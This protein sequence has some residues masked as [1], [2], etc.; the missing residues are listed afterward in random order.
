[1]RLLDYIAAISAYSPDEPRDEKGEWTSEGGMTKLSEVAALPKHLKG[2]RIPPAWTRVQVN[3][4]PKSSLWVK[5]LD[6]KGRVQSI[7]SLKFANSQALKKFARVQ[8]LEAKFAAIEAK[9]EKNR[10][11]KDPVKAD[12]ADALKLI[13]HTG[14]R[15]GSEK[16]TGAEKQAYGATTLLGKHVVK[17]ENGNMSLQFTGKKG[18]DLN[19]PVTDK[20]VASMLEGRMNASGA[21]GKLFANTDAGKLLVYTHSIGGQVKTKDFRTLLANRIAKSEVGTLPEPKDA[22][23]YTKAVKSVAKAVASKLGNTAAVALKSYINPHV[24]SVWADCCG[25]ISR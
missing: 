2:L 21:E 18:V 23:S 3:L 1:M 13:F 7:Y 16:D 24:F 12:S 6:A 9:N 17:D 8:Q 5:G 14:I 22:K 11:A 20:N 25:A 10:G 19:I 15:P 4:D